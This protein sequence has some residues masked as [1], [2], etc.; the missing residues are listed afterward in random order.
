MAMFNKDAGD[1]AEAKATTGGG[2]GALSIIAAGMLVTGDIES[3][4]VVKIEGRV[5]GS[6]RSARQ[7]LVGRQGQVK[8]DIET[9]EAVIG[10]SVDGSITASERTEVQGTAKISGDI[11]TKTI[12]VVEGGAINGTVKMEE[13]VVAGPRVADRKAQPQP[14]AVMR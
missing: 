7:V 3:N 2:D 10:G 12:V 8:G 4:G 11:R 14:V 6:I 1:K 13:N 5:E 9:R